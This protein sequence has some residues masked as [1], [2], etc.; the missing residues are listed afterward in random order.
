MD[1]IAQ[2][3]M[4]GKYIN[5]FNPVTLKHVYICVV[6]VANIY[7]KFWEH[8]GMTENHTIRYKLLIL[9]SVMDGKNIK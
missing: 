6:L 4:R 8:V 9:E 3:T 5:G 2:N 7:Y 1:G